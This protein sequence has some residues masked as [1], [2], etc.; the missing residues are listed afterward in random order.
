MEHLQLTSLLNRTVMHNEGIW[1]SGKILDCRYRDCE[2]VP[3]SHK[4]KLLKGSRYCFFPGINAHVYQCY[5]LGMVKKLICHMWSALQYIAPTPTVMQNDVHAPSKQLLTLMH[6]PLG[7]DNDG[8]LD[9]K[10]LPKGR[11]LT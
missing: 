7:V 6:C 11:K 3:I 10:T 5:T 1:L 9:V 2:F 4:L 8:L